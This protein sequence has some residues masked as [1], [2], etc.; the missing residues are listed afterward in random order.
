ME[1]FSSPVLLSCLDNCVCGEKKGCTVEEYEAA[2]TVISAEESTLRTYAKDE[3]TELAR[4][5]G[6][7]IAELVSDWQKLVSSVL[8]AP[9][10][11]TSRQTSDS[12]IFWAL[13]LRDD[14]IAWTD[15]TRKSGFSIFNNIKTKARMGTSD[16][17]VESILKILINGPRNV[18][19]FDS[20]YY[21]T[22][23]LLRGKQKPRPTSE[24]PPKTCEVPETSSEISDDTK[25]SES[26]I[27]WFP[28]EIESLGFHDAYS[29]ISKQKDFQE[30]TK[31][32]RSQDRI[33]SKIL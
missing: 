13:L 30:N 12:N 1:A 25:I 27:H 33:R 29:V 17:H 6:F 10:W 7:P 32:K 31:Q 28:F 5:F 2:E 3:I 11:K 21:A 23:W 18:N 4:M 24:L 15:M 26:E 20:F 14:K 19:E 9:S 8:S 22:N 16:A